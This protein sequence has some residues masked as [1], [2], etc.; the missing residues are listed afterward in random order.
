MSDT[1]L[2]VAFGSLVL[3]L[4][5]VGLWYLIRLWNSPDGERYARMRIQGPFVPFS[6]EDIAGEKRRE[7]DGQ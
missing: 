5:I 7:Q 3:I 2:I 1:A 6:E 4:L